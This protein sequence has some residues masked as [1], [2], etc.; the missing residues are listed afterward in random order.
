[1][2]HAVRQKF[3]KQR[4]KLNN[5]N[6]SAY[7]QRKRVRNFNMTRGN[8]KDFYADLENNFFRYATINNIPFVIYL[9]KYEKYAVMLDIVMK[10]YAL[11]NIRIS[12]SDICDLLFLTHSSRGN[13]VEYTTHE[14]EFII[15]SD[16]KSLSAIIDTNAPIV[17][18]N[19]GILLYTILTGYL[20]LDHENY[21]F[22]G[23]YRTKQ[24]KDAYDRVSRFA[25]TKIVEILEEMQK[26]TGDDDSYTFARSI[27]APYSFVAHEYIQW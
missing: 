27:I 15:T 22:A 11:D 8:E 4:N 18:S 14:I 20:V 19:R 10:T 6:H 26:R 5:E 25:S 16:N 9:M 13:F 21:G 24:E 23:F 17:G 7:Y 1:M 12:E 2:E 3:L